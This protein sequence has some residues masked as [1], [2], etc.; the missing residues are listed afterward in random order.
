MRASD[1]GI[2]VD[3]IRTKQVVYWVC[4]EVFF[5]LAIV[6]EIYIILVFIKYILNKDHD[7][8]SCLVVPR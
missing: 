7:V 1:E 3:D 8:S 6:C 5:S 4:D 2:A